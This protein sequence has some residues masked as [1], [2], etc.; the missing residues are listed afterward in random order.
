MELPTVSVMVNSYFVLNRLL[1]L[2]VKFVPPKSV[3]LSVQ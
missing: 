1:C 2:L 3:K